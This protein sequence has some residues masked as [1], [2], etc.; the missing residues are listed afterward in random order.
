M[1]TPL[2]NIVLEADRV[3]ES[4]FVP[5]FQPNVQL[6]AGCD[7]YGLWCTPEFRAEMNRWLQDFLGVNECAWKIGN[8]IFVHPEVMKR[9]R[10]IPF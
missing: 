9:L 5:R 6:S 1:P 3:R 7:P 10:N 4:P 2:H 8:T